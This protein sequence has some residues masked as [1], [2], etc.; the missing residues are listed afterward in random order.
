MISICSEAKYGIVKDK[1]G[2]FLIGKYKFSSQSGRLTFGMSGIITRKR[3]IESISYGSTGERM[4]P[5]NY[6]FE[7]NVEI[8]NK[9]NGIIRNNITEIKNILSLQPKKE[10]SHQLNS[11]FFI[12]TDGFYYVYS[13]RHLSEGDGCDLYDEIRCGENDIHLELKYYYYSTSDENITDENCYYLSDLVYDYI[14]GKT[15]Q[16]SDL[17]KNLCDSIYDPYALDIPV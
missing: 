10:M 16:I 7:I 3:G 9:I 4:L 12:Q 17:I 15:L 2:N 6:P 14:K 13:I 11:K 1:Y 8:F 5:S